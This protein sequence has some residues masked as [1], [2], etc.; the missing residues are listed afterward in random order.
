MHQCHRWIEERLRIVN[1]TFVMNSLDRNHPART[2][3]LI[4]VLL[5]M[6]AQAGDAA[7]P[8]SLSTLVPL[9]LILMTVTGA[10]SAPRTISRAPTGAAGWAS[11]AENGAR[12][13]TPAKPVKTRRNSARL[14]PYAIRR[15]S[16]QD[17]V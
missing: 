2:L 16:P 13:A 15:S 7:M 8:F 1:E 6:K 3:P 14:N 5:E 12:A 4:V 10:V 17:V 9:I 11:A